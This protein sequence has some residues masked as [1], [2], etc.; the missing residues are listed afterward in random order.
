MLNIEWATV[1]QNLIY[2]WREHMKFF[3]KFRKKEDGTQHSQV[4]S[5]PAIEPASNTAVTIFLTVQI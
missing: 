4:D 2:G 1:R 3:E 5:Q